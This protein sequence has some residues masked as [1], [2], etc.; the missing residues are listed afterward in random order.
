[1]NLDSFFSFLQTLEKAQIPILLV[2]I[3]VLWL[4]KLDLF[5]L[6]DFFHQRKSRDLNTLVDSLGNH[7]LSDSLKSAIQEKVETE[8]FYRAYGIFASKPYREALV[9]L[10]KKYPLGAE[11]F[12]L[13]RAYPYA[14]ID[15]AG[16]LSFRV[17]RFDKAKVIAADICSWALISIGFVLLAI[18]VLATGAL[19]LGF[20]EAVIKEYIAMN[21]VPMSLLSIFLGLFLNWASWNKRSALKLSELEI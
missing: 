6:L 13:K 11:W 21:V 19:I 20:D 9:K 5:K 8:L 14:D 18:L 17:T 15:K 10:N 12:R 3:V 16:N 1:M 4:L 7:H 2:S